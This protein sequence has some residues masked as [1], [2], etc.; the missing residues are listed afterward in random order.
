MLIIA[1]AIHKKASCITT[2]TLAAHISQA[3]RINCRNTFV[4]IFSNKILSPNARVK[5]CLGKTVVLFI[6]VVTL[7]SEIELMCCCFNRIIKELR[8]AN[9]IR[10]Y[11]REDKTVK[12]I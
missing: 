5:I 12:N 4:S 2:I 9:T 1:R 3:T 11:I 7:E 10:L 8:G 6:Y